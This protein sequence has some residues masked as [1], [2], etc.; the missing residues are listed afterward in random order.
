MEIEVKKLIVYPFKEKEVCFYDLE[1]IAE[2]LNVPFFDMSESLFDE[3]Q[4]KIKVIYDNPHDSDECSYRN[5]LF[6]NGEFICIFGYTGD[7]GY[8]YVSFANYD[9]ANKLRNYFHSLIQVG[10]LHVDIL[11]ESVDI[12]DQYTTFV[13]FGGEFYYQIK[14]PRWSFCLSP[15]VDNLYYIP[16]YDEST[17]L[18]AEFVRWKH[19]N[20]SSCSYEEKNDMILKVDGVEVE[21]DSIRVVFK[22]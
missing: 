8:N 9:V 5:M 19:K 4:F 22:C 7:R 17:L 20:E 18:K 13:D 14:S 21:S 2:E 10:D 3:T 12:S 16:S 6:F 1:Y 11:D 15:K